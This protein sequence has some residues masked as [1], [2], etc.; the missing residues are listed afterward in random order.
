MPHLEIVHHA[1]PT[2][3]GRLKQ[4][5]R[6]YTLGGL[7]LKDPELRKKLGWGGDATAAGV[8]V[9]HDS[10][11]S[12]S[13]FWAA[14]T[15]IAGDASSLPLVLYR[16]LPQGGKA[17]ATD[18]RL[19]DLLHARPNSEMTSMGW[20]E[21]WM[22]HALAWGNG[23]CEIERDKGGRP[24]AIWPF[25]PTQVQ[26]FRNEALQ[27]KYRVWSPT[28]REVIIDP[29]NMLHLRG[30]SYDGLVGYDV[31]AKAH[32][33]LGLS[34]AT[35]KFG[36][37]FFGNGTTFGGALK[38]PKTLSPTAQKTLR[39]SIESRHQGPE[40][41][42]RLL[43][44]EEGMG[45]EKFGTD[46]NDAQFLET[47]VFQ[48]REVARFFKLPPSKLGDLAD[49]TFSNVSEETLNYYT[50]CL[51]PWL[52]RVEQELSAKLLTRQ[53]SQTLLAEHVVEGLL[54]A[55]IEQRGAFYALMLNNGAMTP[56]EVR[57]LENLPPIAGGDVARA[58]MNTAPLTVLA[59]VPPTKK[60][61]A[62]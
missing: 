44:L 50:S 45:F 56:N 31:V 58:P 53:E 57:A 20:R 34:L 48:I 40:R 32:Q 21:T 49:A 8:N 5:L 23:Y 37:T 11:L 52:T 26:P 18:H 2:L 7:S 46:P 12:V 29:A 47:R 55:N 28:G 22:L 4:T 54:R 6:S 61:E 36:A 14:T 43:I 3:W 35:E 27:L 62:A 30:P 24:F 60:P 17:R 10:A 42:H 39:D 59:G 15:L 38:H 13:A 51:R 1:P 9:D 41:A 19:Y 16:R 33:A 25:L